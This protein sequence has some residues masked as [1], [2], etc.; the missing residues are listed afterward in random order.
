MD[1]SEDINKDKSHNARRNVWLEILAAYGTFI[2]LAI[3]NWW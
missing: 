2:C 3:W 1:S